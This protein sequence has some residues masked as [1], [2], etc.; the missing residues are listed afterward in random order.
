M[1]LFPTGNRRNSRAGEASLRL[2]QTGGS[3]HAGGFSFRP[4]AA[5]VSGAERNRTHQ[6]QL[7]LNLQV[8]RQSN[9]GGA[10]KHCP[11]LK[12]HDC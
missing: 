12:K 10:R 9:C 6:K 3:F 5:P 4:N 2:G 1:I 7:T 11:I 8:W